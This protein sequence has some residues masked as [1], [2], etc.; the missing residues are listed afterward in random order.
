[1]GPRHQIWPLLLPGRTCNAS[2]QGLLLL[3]PLLVRECYLALGLWPY[4]FIRFSSALPLQKA[5]VPAIQ[6]AISS[7]NIG[8]CR[9]V[10]TAPNDSTTSGRV[11]SKG[12]GFASARSSS[13]FSPTSMQGSQAYL[14][15]GL[16]ILTKPVL[17]A[18]LLLDLLVCRVQ[19]PTCS[20]ASQ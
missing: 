15:K 8:D 19:K 6:G 20:R 4:H 9:T 18:A 10:P 16:A 1:M 3:T 5:G 2:L 14:F 7:K 11:L 17:G 12:K 13:P